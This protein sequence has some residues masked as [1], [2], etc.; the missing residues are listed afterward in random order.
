[1]TNDTGLQIA[2]PPVFDLTGSEFSE[3]SQPTKD[4]KGKGKEK[5]SRQA[6]VEIGE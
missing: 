6:T 4:V 1:M 2:R 3:L 5:V